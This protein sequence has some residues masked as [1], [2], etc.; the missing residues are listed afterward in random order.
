MTDERNMS[1]EH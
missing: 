1:M